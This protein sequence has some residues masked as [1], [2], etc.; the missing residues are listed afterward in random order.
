MFKRI[1]QRLGLAYYLIRMRLKRHREKNDFLRQVREAE[2]L[3]IVIGSS[4]VF[5]AG[6]IPTDYQHLNLLNPAHWDKAFQGRKL[7]GLLAEHVWEHLNAED[8]LLALKLVSSH[9][10]SGARIR[11]AVPDGY[12][13]DRAYIDAVKPGGSGAGSDDH[14]V[15]YNVDSLE[16]A[17]TE[18]GFRVERLEYYDAEG[19]FHQS[20]WAPADGMV[21]RSLQYDERNV[22][23]KIG[24]T[25]LILDGF[26]P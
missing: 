9:L 6:W 21:H 11:L 8:G 4:G 16:R 2:V 22:D 14:K 7:D 15:L 3:K 10:K 5:E 13:P 26:K 1:K 12:S 25:S 24:Y 18:A 19:R 20:P 17:M 23:G